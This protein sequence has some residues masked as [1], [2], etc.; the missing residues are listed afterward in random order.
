LCNLDTLRPT[1]PA[2]HAEG[3]DELCP[4]C[5]SSPLFFVAKREIE[6]RSAAGIESLAFLELATPLGHVSL[7]DELSP[8]DEELRSKRLVCRRWFGQDETRP[9]A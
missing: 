1:V 3:L 2:S 8:I 6:Q 5:R 9:R 7:V 4:G